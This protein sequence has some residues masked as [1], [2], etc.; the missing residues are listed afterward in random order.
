MGKAIFYC[1]VVREFT[2]RDGEYY[3]YFKECF[4]SMQRQMRRSMIAS[5]GVARRSHSKV[6]S[7]ARPALP[8]AVSR[9]LD[10][11]GRQSA[12]PSIGHGEVCQRRVSRDAPRS[13]EIVP[14]PP[15]ELA[16]IG[17]LGSGARGTNHRHLLG[18]VL[19]DLRTMNKIRYREPGWLKYR[20]KITMDCGATG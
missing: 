5:A 13:R 11:L 18:H 17:D 20:Q 9:E 3:L 6:G 4:I 1:C 2:R 7:A 8:V 12:R 10:A 16:G 15:V 14:S 19:S